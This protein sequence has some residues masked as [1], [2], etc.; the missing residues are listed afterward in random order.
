MRKLFIGVLA[1]M[2]VA[3]PLMAI[4]LPNIYSGPALEVYGPDGWSGEWTDMWLASD[5]AGKW[6]LSLAVGLSTG[7]EKTL[8]ISVDLMYLFNHERVMFITGGRYSP[9]WV[10]GGLT[11]EGI[12]YYVF[13]H[14]KTLW[15]VGIPACLIGTLMFIYG[16]YKNINRI[17]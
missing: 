11:L 15:W 8:G 12:G 17:L 1:V 6:G 9:F 5:L 10:L 3:M 13:L 14:G 16:I 2:F 7:G 4:E